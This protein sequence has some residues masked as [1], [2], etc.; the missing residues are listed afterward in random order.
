VCEFGMV[1][2]TFKID[3]LVPLSL[4]NF[5]EMVALKQVYG[6]LSAT[7]RGRLEKL[8]LTNAYEKYIAKS[9]QR[10][11]DQSRQRSMATRAAATA[12]DTAIAVG[13]ADK[14]AVP[15]LAALSYQPSSQPAR[16]G[17]SHIVAILKEQKARYWVRWSQPEGAEEET[18]ENKRFM[19][20]SEAHREVVLTWR[21]SRASVQ[22]PEI[23]DVVDMTE[24][25]ERRQRR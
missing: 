1:S 14:H 4:N 2:S 12:A 23:V 11:V 5:P 3:K 15:S 22:P 19:E 18:W 7:E 20:T 16:S 8:T 13:Q 21:A 10:T 25:G 17:P 24:G 9:K 6:E